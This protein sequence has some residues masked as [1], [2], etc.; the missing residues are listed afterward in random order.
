L[1]YARQAQLLALQAIGQITQ[2]ARQE[3]QGSTKGF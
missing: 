1:D 2:A 3:A